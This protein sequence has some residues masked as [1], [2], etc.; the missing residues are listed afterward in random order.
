MMH[1][2]KSV[3]SVSRIEVQEDRTAAL[4]RDGL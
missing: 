4:L 3:R 1:H 2:L